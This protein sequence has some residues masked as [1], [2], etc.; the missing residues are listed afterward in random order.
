MAG[1]KAPRRKAL[2]KPAKAKKAKAPKKPVLTKKHYEEHYEQIRA[3]E[4]EVREL[5]MH[6]DL[7]KAEASRRKKEFEESDLEL[8]NLISRGPDLQTKLPF[9]GGNTAESKAAMA[10]SNGDGEAWR[11]VKIDA[12]GLPP[13]VTEKLVA[14]DMETM[15]RLED[16]RSQIILGREKWPKGIGEAKVTLI[17][18][19]MIKWLTANRDKHGEPEAAELATASNG[20]GH[21]DAQA[22][23]TAEVGQA[24]DAA[25][26][27]DRRD[28]PVG[29]N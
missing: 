1:T 6:A 4:R 9:D 21:A 17:E 5:E 12:L 20:D 24:F 16:R 19:A 25:G 27:L 10:A 3:K 7:A 14:A 2:K 13:A 29:A 26:I 23:H 18:D 8:R 28:L 15:G 22:E 11:A